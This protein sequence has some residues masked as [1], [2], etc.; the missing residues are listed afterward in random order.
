MVMDWGEL[1]SALEADEVRWDV[2]YDAMGDLE[3]E[4]YIFDKLNRRG[5]TLLEIH[6][7][8]RAWEEDSSPVRWRCREVDVESTFGIDA[9]PGRVDVIALREEQWFGAFTEA[10]PEP[11]MLRP[12]RD[13][14][15]C[16]RGFAYE[17]KPSGRFGLKPAT[18]RLVHAVMLPEEE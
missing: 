11:V 18:P 17:V 1:R 2:V 4:R 14:F 3:A 12:H 9:P 16:R 5:W 6:K 15:V 10:S 13:H 8:L 7:A